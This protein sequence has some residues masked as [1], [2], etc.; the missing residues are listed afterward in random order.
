MRRGRGR[1]VP[2]SGVGRV[3]WKASFPL[4][5]PTSGSHTTLAGK[6]AFHTGATSTSIP[7]Q[8]PV[9]TPLPGIYQDARP[10]SVSSSVTELLCRLCGLFEIF[11]STLPTVLTSICKPVS[12]G[13]EHTNPTTSAADSNEPRTTRGK[14]DPVGQRIRIGR[15]I[16]PRRNITYTHTR[17]LSPRYPE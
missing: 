3:S 12:G 16:N 1:G 13:L 5:S 4:P 8:G 9:Y 2:G 6:P 7:H 15:H 17:S 10:G 14:E 11:S